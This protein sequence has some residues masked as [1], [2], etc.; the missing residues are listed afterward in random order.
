MIQK[1]VDSSY[2]RYN[3]VELTRNVFIRASELREKY[4]FSY[5][6][7]IIVSAAIIANCNIL[8]SEDMQHELIVENRLQIINP[9][10]K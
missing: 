5:Y 3:V 8:Y 7:S 4:N 1:F 2:H 6:D 9:F 10:K